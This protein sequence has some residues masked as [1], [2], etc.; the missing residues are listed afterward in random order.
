MRKRVQ[1]RSQSPV[2]EPN[3]SQEPEPNPRVSWQ[4]KALLAGWPVVLVLFAVSWTFGCGSDSTKPDP[5]SVYRYPATQDELI[6]AYRDAY[7]FRIADDVD[8]LLTDDFVFHFAPID[9]D[10]FQVAGTWG[11]DEEMASCRRLFG[12]EQGIWPTGELRAPIDSLFYFGLQVR[13]EKESEWELDPDS[14]LWERPYLASMVI[15]YDDGC[16]DIVSGVQ[17]FGVQ[18][19]SEVGGPNGEQATGFAIREWR[20]TGLIGVREEENPQLHVASWGYVKASFRV[21]E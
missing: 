3:Q 10:S 6:A 4:G 19:M 14:G 16:I 1:T 17:R 5:P 12:G 18:D 20:D 7:E 9:I 21:R 15:Q 2:R 8:E 11:K 13:P